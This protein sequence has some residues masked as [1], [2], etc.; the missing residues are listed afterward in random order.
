[1]SDIERSVALT[2]TERRALDYEL[3]VDFDCATEPGFVAAVERIIADRLAAAEG[4]V[5]RVEALVTAAEAREAA[6]LSR[7]FD[8]G[9]FGAWVDV[10]RLRAALAPEPTDG[11][12]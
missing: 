4:A 8:G 10:D 7:T 3:P 2:D 1:M 9:S 6:S 11:A 12:V 5:A